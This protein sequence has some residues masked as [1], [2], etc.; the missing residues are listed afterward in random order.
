MLDAVRAY[1][2][3]GLGRDAASISRFE[4]GN[5]HHVFRADDVVVRVS[6]TDDA[7][8]RARAQHE[9]TVLEALAGRAAP[10]LLDLR[11][12]SRWFTAPVM[13]MTFVSG[14]QLALVDASPAQIEQLGAVVAGVH[15]TPFGSTTDTIASYAEAR[16]RHIFGGLPWLRDPLPADLREPLRAA[17]D[18]LGALDAAS[19]EPL[20]LLHGDIALG[21]VL[22]GPDPVLIDWEYARVGDPADEIAYLFDQNELDA[23]QRD[24]FWCGYRPST[25]IVER[26]AWWEPLTLLGS[27]LWW[28]E[29]FVRRS[30]H[31]DDPE[32]P[33]DATYYLQEIQR[34]V[35][36]L[37]RS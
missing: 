21:N 15:R 25:G 13:S 16:R 17:A 29:R 8:E 10:R 23:T 9:A 27:T 18:A 6:L 33:K 37:Q 19:P 2:A 30:E 31:E 20:A 32:V 7:V 22:W 3:E 4:A 36:R 26:I 1:V 24:A 5:R 11:L 12:T 28:A 35:N 14:E 34:R